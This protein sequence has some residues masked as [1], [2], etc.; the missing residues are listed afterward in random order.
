MEFIRHLTNGIL[1]GLPLVLT[2]TP[3]HTTIPGTKKPTV[4]YMVNLEYRGSLAEMAQAIKQTMDTR[5]L[6][7][8][9]VKDYEKLA[10]EALTL[11]EAPEECK[12]VVEEF[13]PESVKVA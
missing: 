3:K 10:E 5:A 13:Y 7:Q 1:A 12:D 6:M 4:I 11:P 9:S 8:Y 2:L